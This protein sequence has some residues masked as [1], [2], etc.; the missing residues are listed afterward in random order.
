MLEFDPRR[1]V[2]F[3]TTSTVLVDGSIE[4]RFQTFQIPEAINAILDLNRADQNRSNADR[5]KAAISSFGLVARIPQILQRQ[6]EQE[7]GPQIDGNE[8]AWKRR[9]NDLDYRDLRTDTRK[10]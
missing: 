1:G 6:W 10:L 7:L 9:L 2:G 5:R 8:A 3:R 4:H